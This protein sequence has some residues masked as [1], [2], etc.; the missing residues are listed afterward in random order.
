MFQKIRS[1]FQ[2][3]LVKNGITLLSASTISQIIALIVYPIITRQYSPEELGVLAVF[4]PIVGIGTILASGK[5]ELAIMVEK[6]KKDAAAAFDISFFLTLFLV[7]LTSVLVLIFKPWLIKT[8]KLESI[9][10]FMNFIP[11][12]IFLSSLGFI[13]TYWFN[14]NK[15]FALTARYNIVQSSVNSGLKVGFGSLG[16]TQWGLIAASIIGQLM[17]VLSV[18]FK[19]KDFEK[20]F[21]FEKLRMIKVAKKQANF[22]KYTL[23]HAFVNTLASSVPIMILAVY[24]DMAEVGLF[25]LGITIGFKPISILTGSMN[26]VLFQKSTQNKAEGI[27]SFPLLLNFCRKT[28]LIA[29]PVFIIAYLFLPP[30]VEWLFGHAWVKAGEYIQLMLPWFLAA[31]MASSLSYMPA[32][33]GKQFTAMIIEIVYATCKISVLFIGVLQND[34]RLAILLFSIVNALFVSGLL[35]WFLYLAKQDTA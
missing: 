12:L 6:R 35:V 1:S 7:I 18:F 22:P 13:L 30:T 10:L 2:S 31:L 21:K 27:S 17:G 9:S 24:F 14:R 26:Q 19:K 20:L 25:A 3:E 23:P 29:T 33:A 5:Y 11:L 32:V 34:I 28:L 8:F 15:R 16:L 4:L